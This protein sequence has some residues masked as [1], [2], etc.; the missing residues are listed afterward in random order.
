MED[1]EIKKKIPN[2]I[3]LYKT[4]DYL[5]GRCQRQVKYRHKLA[6]K[7]NDLE[8]MY[9]NLLEEHKKLMVE[10]VRLKLSK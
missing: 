10:N 1:I 6:R 8:Y 7:F 3:N 9:N 4:I 5:K 2:V